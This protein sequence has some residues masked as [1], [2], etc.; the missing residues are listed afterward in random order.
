MKFFFFM[1]IQSEYYYFILT[2]QSFKE[3]CILLIF[4]LSK[5]SGNLINS[6]CYRNTGVVFFKGKIRMLSFVLFPSGTFAHRRVLNTM[7]IHY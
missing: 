2:A 4:S 5:S 6:L 7:H 3:F 1:C